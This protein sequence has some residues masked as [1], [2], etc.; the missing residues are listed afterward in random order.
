VYTS[1]KADEQQPQS[2]IVRWVHVNEGHSIGWSVQPH[3]KSINF[4]IFKH[5]GTKNGLA[6]GMPTSSSATL[7]PPPSAHSNDEHLND[8]RKRRGSVA[9]HEASTV[10]EKLHN[11]GLRC[12]EWVGNCEADKV[13]V[14]TYDVAPGQGGMYGL[15]FDNTFSKTVSKTATLV[16][17]TQGSAEHAE[18]QGQPAHRCY[19]W[20]LCRV[21]GKRVG[22]Y[23]ACQG[24]ESFVPSVAHAA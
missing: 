18:P 22:K 19:T 15:V 10:M 20:C 12:V 23:T 2:Y 5:P 13:R 9:K 17:M 7:E 16:L 4:G 24:K 11:I 3:K 21:A 1:C 6:P 8:G 14:G